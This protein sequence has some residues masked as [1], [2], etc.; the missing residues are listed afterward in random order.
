MNGPRS[1]FV[2]ALLLLAGCGG[3]PSKTEALE[4]VQQGQK[5]EA[6]CTL[7]I[8]MLS[9]LKM[10]HVT[11]SVCVAMASL[12]E[13][14]GPMN[15]QMACLDALVAA[16]ASKRMSQS[17]MLE[18]PDETT[19]AGF[20]RISPYDRKS[21]DLVFRG[22]IEMGDLREGRF[23]CGHAKVDHIVRITKK[24]EKQALVRYGR[25][26]TL[27]PALAQVEAACGTVTRPAPESSVTVE[28]IDK[29]WTIRPDPAL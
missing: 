9:K 3:L 10:Q 5:E 15:A 7:P 25:E 11:K 19:A 13:P 2:S 21:R 26:I 4:I 8:E 29:K 12:G 23:T 22:C 1:F 20:D 16:G 6:G 27:D 14:P 28:S 18:W 24:T 17:Y